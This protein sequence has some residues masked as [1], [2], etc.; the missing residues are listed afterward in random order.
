MPNRVIFADAESVDEFQLYQDAVAELPDV[1]VERLTRRK[2]AILP[3]SAVN[4]PAKQIHTELHGDNKGN[5]V[6]MEASVAGGDRLTKMES[7]CDSFQVRLNTHF[8]QS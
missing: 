4:R 6:L 2:R 1:V 3:D 5:Q 7:H 8:Q